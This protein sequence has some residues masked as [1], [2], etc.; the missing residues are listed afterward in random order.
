MRYI[1]PGMALT[2]CTRAIFRPVCGTGLASSTVSHRLPSPSGT[3]AT[4]REARGVATASRR[5]GTGECWQR[6]ARGP[7]GS[8]HSPSLS[9]VYPFSFFVLFCPGYLSP[10]RLPPS[11]LPATS[12]GL[13]P[14]CLPLRMTPF[15][16]IFGFLWGSFSS[17]I[18]LPPPP[19]PLPAEH[20]E[21]TREPF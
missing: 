1:S 16:A 20:P 15:S 5:T 11:M 12:R 4:G 6:E 10:W 7:S 14:A 13:H 8:N 21:G 19:H 17:T 3:R 2:R 9:P 18:C